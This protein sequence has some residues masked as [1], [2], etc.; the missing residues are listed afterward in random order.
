MSKG[1]RF[2]TPDPN[3]TKQYGIIPWI[4]GKFFTT[5]EHFFIALERGMETE[6]R[7]INISMKQKL[8]WS[9]P[10]RHQDQ[11]LNLPPRHVPWLESNPRPFG[12]GPTLQLKATLAKALYNF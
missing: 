2:H 6:G 1:H 7:E 11:E 10:H 12:Y 9:P 5:Q 3:K 4:T 8:N